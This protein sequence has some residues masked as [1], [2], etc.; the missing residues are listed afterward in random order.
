MI[1]AVAG[2]GGRGGPGGDE[3]LGPRINVAH[4]M[5]IEQAAERDWVP[6]VAVPG[7]KSAVP[8][9]YRYEWLA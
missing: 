9:M 1:S 4:N 5:T 7:T 3:K 8:G 2:F 6:A